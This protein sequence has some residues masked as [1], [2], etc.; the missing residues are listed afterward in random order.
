MSGLEFKEALSL[1][2]LESGIADN[3]IPGLATATLNFRYPL[4]RT[5]AEAEAFL[6]S[7]VPE[8]PR[9]RS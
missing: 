7:L 9:S 3:V 6:A 1:T 5:P 2:R 8:E 4:D